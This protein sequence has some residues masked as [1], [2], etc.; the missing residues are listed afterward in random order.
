[1]KVFSIEKFLND[2]SIL[3]E[4]KLYC[5]ANGWPQDCEGKSADKTECVFHDTWM[6]EKEDVPENNIFDSSK[7]LTRDT[8]Y[9]AKKGMVGRFA[10]SISSLEN[11]AEVRPTMGLTDIHEHSGFPFLDS[12]GCCYRFFY[13][14]LTQDYANCQ[15]YWIVEHGWS[16]GDKVTVKENWECSP[17]YNVIQGLVKV[18]DTYEILGFDEVDGIIS[19]SPE[20]EGDVCLPYFAIEKTEKAYIPFSDADMV[21]LT[22]RK[23]ECNGKFF[24]VTDCRVMA[25][26]GDDW[27]DAEEMF[28]MFTIG[29]KPCGIEV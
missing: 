6:V 13:P 12:Y 19:N 5:L 20:F 7:V 18:G 9:K 1:M 25:K 8:A 17:F 24:E 16:V 28:D 21:E 26:I 22:G 3:V 23:V 2:P 10:N 29:G 15:Y 14:D 4:V 11:N 27:F